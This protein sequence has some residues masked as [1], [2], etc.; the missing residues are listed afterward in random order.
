MHSIL[1][2]PNEPSY[3]ADENRDAAPGQI[4]FLE[5]PPFC[6]PVPVPRNNTTANGMERSNDDHVLIP[7]MPMSR[8][9]DVH[10]STI[11]KPL[12]GRKFAVNKQGAPGAK[13]AVIPLTVPYENSDVFPKR[14]SY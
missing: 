2:S 3:R 7:L 9:I 12:L 13:N 6:V 11:G 10:L 5:H 8:R 4:V 1:L 14:C